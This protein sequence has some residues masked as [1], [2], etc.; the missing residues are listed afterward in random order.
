VVAAA[1][2]S[3]MCVL[4]SLVVNAAS[5]EEERQAGEAMKRDWDFEV[6]GDWDN[7]ELEVCFGDTPL[8]LLLLLTL[9]PLLLL[10]TVEEEEE[11]EDM[12]EGGML[13]RELLL[14][15]LFEPKGEELEVLDK[16]DAKL[17]SSI[18]FSSCTAYVDEVG[19]VGDWIL[20]EG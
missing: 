20:L 11:D 10:V 12:D 3:S 13:L 9:S 8:S 18:V 7:L 6:F 2:A 19:D 15:A 14:F 1:A 5:R 4:G 16:G 17:N